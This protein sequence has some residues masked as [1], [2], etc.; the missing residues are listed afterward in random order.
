[1]SI[2]K[3]PISLAKKLGYEVFFNLKDF[4]FIKFGV[5]KIPYLM[6]KKNMVIPLE[7]NKDHI[8]VA[9]ADPL[10]L[11]ILDEIYLFLAKPVK[12][13]VSEAS[14]IEEAIEFCYRQ[15]EGETKRLVKNVN[16]S[17]KIYDKSFINNQ[18]EYDLLDRSD[19]NNFVVQII[20]GIIMEAIQQKASDIHF[21]PKENNIV[22]RYRID[23]I[24]LDRVTVSNE[25]QSQIITRIKV[26]SN[27]DIAEKRLPQDGRLKLKMGSRQID[28][29][30][31]IIPVIFGERIVMRIL[32]KSNL[33]LGLDKLGMAN[34]ALSDFRKLINMPEGIILV[35]G[36]T[37]S[38]K[39]TTLYSAINE[40]NTK[41]KN[42]ITIEEPVEYNIESISQISVNPKIDLTFS[43]GL[44][45]ILRQDPDVIMVGEIRDKETAEIAIQASLTGHLVFS[46]LHTNDAASAITRLAEMG[47]EKYLLSSSIIC[48]L[49]QRLL[50]KL[51]DN[52]KQ[53]YIPT[54]EEVKK[55]SI[56]EGDVLYKSIGCDLCFSTGFKDRIGIYELLKINSNIKKEILEKIDAEKIKKIAIKEKMKDL[57]SQG[58]N[59]VKQGITTFDEV[60]RV[61]RA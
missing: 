29:R 27:L 18:E 56:D 2:K 41:E 3:D 17:K 38:G 48:V 57:Y 19:D 23:G 16:F 15:E 28:F 37:G 61:T 31:S 51:C 10:N 25:Y 30:I 39:T 44:R 49:A 7:E 5:K 36:P 4:Y 6:A 53:E 13:I 34:E 20:N 32:D 43:K 9:I 60:I 59:L 11:S 24:L 8:I 40:L 42:L 26:M 58:I 14:K 1:M 22:V 47:I 52:C 12:A 33:I 54:K 55:M 50:R 45:H 46:T 21:D 35:T